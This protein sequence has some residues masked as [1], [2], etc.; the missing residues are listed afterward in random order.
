[1]KARRILITSVL[2][3]TGLA[4]ATSAGLAAPQTRPGIQPF[5]NVP[6][7]C[8]LNALPDT[9]SLYS[10]TKMQIQALWMARRGERANAGVLTS[11][12]DLPMSEVAAMIRGMREEHI[13][14]T[15]AAFILSAFTASTNEDAATIAKIL[16]TA[17]QQLAGMTD[18]LLGIILQGTQDRDQG[19]TRDRF[20]QW[21]SRRR[22]LLAKMTE[23]LNVSLSLLVD[24]RRRNADGKADRMILTQAQ[25]DDLLMYVNS[26]FPALEKEKKIGH[27][28]DFIEQALLIQSFL[29]GGLKPA[30]AQ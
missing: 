7:G 17:Y 18:Q 28:G 10:F 5:V 9:G 21:K 20:A 22:D 6:E 2:F 19:A 25:R 11:R 13:E 27:S 14:D 30:D 23:A 1:M 8:S 26:K 15:C 29:T 16:S 3:S 12:E 4:Q 24:E